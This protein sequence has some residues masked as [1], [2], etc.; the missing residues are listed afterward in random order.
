MNEYGVPGTFTMFVK[1]LD[2]CVF[3]D[4]DML[5]RYTKHAI[6]VLSQGE[7]KNKNHI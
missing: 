4:E 1:I 5:E 7:K 2:P 6:D 3:Y